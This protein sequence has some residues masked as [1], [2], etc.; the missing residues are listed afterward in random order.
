MRPHLHYED[1][2]AGL[3]RPRRYGAFPRHLDARAVA[4]AGGDLHH[5]LLPLLDQPRS[6][7]G[8]AGAPPDASRAVARRARHRPAHGHVE[9]RAAERVHEVDL[10]RLLQIE[11]PFGRLVR[12]RAAAEDVAEDVREARPLLRGAPAASARPATSRPAEAEVESRPRIAP[13]GEAL[14]AL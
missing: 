6:R 1:E 7:A 2:V 14:P 4:H 11:R 9:G 10:Q 5:E 8:A 12:L 3:F 13:E